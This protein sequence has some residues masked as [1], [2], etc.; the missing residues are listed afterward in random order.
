MLSESHVAATALL[1]RTLGQTQFWRSH[2]AK[3]W[4]HEIKEAL[5]YN[6]LLA[7]I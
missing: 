1:H 2:P 3:S 7:I 5:Q 6:A 4:Q